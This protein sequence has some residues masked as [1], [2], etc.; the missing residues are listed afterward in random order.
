MVLH[1]ARPPAYGRDHPLTNPLTPSAPVQPI[2]ESQPRHLGEV[3]GVPGQQ[4]GLVDECD[5]GD[6]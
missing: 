4:C 6:L 5:A 3:A 2:L 1:N